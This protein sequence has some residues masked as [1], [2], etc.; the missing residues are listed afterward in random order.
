MFSW[1]ALLHAEVIQKHWL[2][3]YM[4]TISSRHLQ[5]RLMKLYREFNNLMQTRKERRKANYTEKIKCFNAS[6]E[7]FDI[8]EENEQS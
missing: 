5:T 7:V 3:F 6:A 2:F 1:K 4:Y 8:C